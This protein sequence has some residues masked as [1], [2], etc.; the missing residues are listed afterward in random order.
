M[1]RLSTSGTDTANIRS[2]VLCPLQNGYVLITIQQ[3]VEKSVD[4]KSTKMYN[5]S[6][7]I[8][9][10][11]IISIFF[12]NKGRLWSA[13][14]LFPFT[15]VGGIWQRSRCLSGVLGY[16]RAAQ[17]LRF[18]HI[19]LMHLYLGAPQAEGGRAVARQVEPENQRPPQGGR[20]GHPLLSLV[21]GR[22]DP[23]RDRPRRRREVRVSARSAAA[24]ERDGAGRRPPTRNG[25]ESY[26]YKCCRKKIVGGVAEAVDA[27]ECALC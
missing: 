12:Q 26:P 3:Q 4:K 8:P 24:R 20:N 7:W 13:S 18:L 16:F 22:G 23:R 21:R 17:V 11:A 15:A 2:E 6:A 1:R 14:D 10:Q 5:E 19:T 25:G 9:I 27:R